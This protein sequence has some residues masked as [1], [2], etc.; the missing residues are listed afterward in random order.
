M[1]C[2]VIVFLSSCS[3]FFFIFYLYTTAKLQVLFFI[4]YQM[5]RGLR[6]KVVN[7]KKLQIYISSYRSHYMRERY[8][9]PRTG[10]V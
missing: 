2:F 1:K 8:A 9:V 4:E 10:D 6:K 5:M 7:V 3:R